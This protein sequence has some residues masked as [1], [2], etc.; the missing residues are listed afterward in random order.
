MICVE[1]KQDGISIYVM[2]YRPC[3]GRRYICTMYCEVNIL[4]VWCTRNWLDFGF[5]LIWLM[6]NSVGDS[7]RRSSCSK[8]TTFDL[9]I[10]YSI[11]DDDLKVYMHVM[12]VEV[13][14]L[15]IDIVSLLVENFMNTFSFVK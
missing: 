13:W 15:S 11:C 2:M 1:L 7:L 6:N 8:H 5:F 3:C 14:H 12:P 9:I 10:I 4:Y